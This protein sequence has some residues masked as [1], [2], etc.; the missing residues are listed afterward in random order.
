MSSNFHHLD[1]VI[2]I[3]LWTHLTRFPT[4]T[5]RIFSSRHPCQTCRLQKAKR[6]NDHRTT[7]STNGGVLR[8]EN[9]TNSYGA[10][11]SNTRSIDPKSMFIYGRSIS[12]H[13]VKKRATVETEK[14][15]GRKRKLE[16]TTTDVVTTAVV[17]RVRTLPL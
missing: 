13:P 8:Q 16:L 4:S 5:S 6:D 14:S 17:G 15:T 3:Y 9:I 1:H 11:Q 2:H 10:G 7:C 12:C